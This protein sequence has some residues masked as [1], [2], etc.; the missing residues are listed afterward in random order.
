MT[1]SCVNLECICHADWY[2]VTTSLFHD[3]Y[4]STDITF[5]LPSFWIALQSAKSLN[6]NFLIFFFRYNEKLCIW[7]CF[8]FSLFLD[9]LLPM[10]NFWPIQLA[11]YI[12]YG[13]RSDLG[14]LNLTFM[15]EK[16]LEYSGA[17]NFSMSQP[18]KGFVGAH[19]YNKCSLQN[20]V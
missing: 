7:V 8:C 2:A 11:W 17:D 5:G 3:V 4:Q 20:L 12:G 14:P 6:N 15:A 10:F 16:N 9:G 19:L 1:I 18:K 13:E